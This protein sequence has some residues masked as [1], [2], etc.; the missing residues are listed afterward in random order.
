MCSGKYALNKAVKNF[1]TFH[2]KNAENSENT[3]QNSIFQ[4]KI[5]KCQT[6][7]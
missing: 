1:L 6:D 5:V 4:K 7:Q 2:R 3:G